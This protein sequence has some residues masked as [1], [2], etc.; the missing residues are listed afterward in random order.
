MDGTFLLRYEG[1]REYYIDRNDDS[2]S[3]DG[4]GADG[5][6]G[7]DADGNDDGDFYVKCKYSILFH[8]FWVIFINRV[9]YTNEK[10]NV[11]LDILPE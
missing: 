3:L 11:L 7:D 8:G 5:N 2:D 1:Q 4:D 6:D 10:E 9:L